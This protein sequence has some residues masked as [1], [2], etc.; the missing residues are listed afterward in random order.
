M[1]LFIRRLAV[2]AAMSLVLALVG[3][4][5]AWK[6]GVFSPAPASS[7]AVAAS[8]KYVLPPA[9]KGVPVLS[10]SCSNGYVTF[11]F[12]DGPGR[13]TLPLASELLAEHVPAVFF[14]IGD[15]VDA[16]PGITKILVQHHFVIGDHT[17]DH[18]SMTGA[19]TGTRPLTDKQARSELTRA[20][21][22]IEAAGAPRPTLWRPPYGDVFAM[23]NAIGKSLGLRLVM[24]WSDNGTIIDDLDWTAKVTPAKIIKAVTQGKAPL[25]NGVIVAGHDG[26]STSG[27]TVKA[28]PA[29]VAYMNRHQLCATAKVRA[30]ATGGVLAGS[31]T[32]PGGSGS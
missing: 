32:A 19:S 30:D 7:A 31:A 11:T 5:V 1:K 29:I 13:Y 3:T 6:D 15:N 8:V 17:Y 12:D 26:I 22:S 27:D 2:L 14:E 20:A 10:N 18:K 25:R 21:A 24:P 16:R 4:S 23:D 28:M 9:P